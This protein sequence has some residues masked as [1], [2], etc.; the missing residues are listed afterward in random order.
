MNPSSGQEDGAEERFHVTM[1]FREGG[2]AVEGT[3]TDA[4]VA[5]NKFRSWLG[6]HGS[7]DGITI[8]LEV[9]AGAGREPLRTW[10]KEHGEHIHDADHRYRD[11]T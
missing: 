11:S 9:G 3:W 7:R 2:P 1:T 5:L 8:T 6:T 10:T 4:G